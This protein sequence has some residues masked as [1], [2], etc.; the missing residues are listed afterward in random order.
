[1]TLIQY[2][3]LHVWKWQPGADWQKDFKK[4]TPEELE[5][6]RQQCSEYVNNPPEHR[7]SVK[8]IDE[9]WEYLG[10][11]AK[12]C[13]MSRSELIEQFIKD[14]AGYRRNGSDEEAAAQA[15]YERGGY[16]YF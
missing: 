12:A 1:M 8:L 15:W 9:E 14:F 4:L 7:L 11:R 13:H 10:E 6:V 5:A 3:H 16:E 2:Y